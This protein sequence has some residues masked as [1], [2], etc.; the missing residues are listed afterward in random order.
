MVLLKGYIHG[1]HFFNKSSWSDQYF[2]GVISGWWNQENVNVGFL[3]PYKCFLK[4]KKNFFLK[5]SDGYMD[6]IIIILIL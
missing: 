1:N 4:V 2:N 6:F 3:E 5:N